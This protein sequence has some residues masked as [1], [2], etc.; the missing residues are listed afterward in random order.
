MAETARK[1]ASPSL[2]FFVGVTVVPLWKEPPANAQEVRARADLI[3]EFLET[4]NRLG[5]L[6]KKAFQGKTSG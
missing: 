3:G 6:L 1:S 5:E 2:D 4:S